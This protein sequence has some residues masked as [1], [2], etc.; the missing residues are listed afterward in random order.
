MRPESAP[1]LIGFLTY[2]S[3]IQIYD[4]INNGHSHIICDVSSTFP[5]LTTFLVDPLVHFEQ[6]ERYLTFD[7]KHLELIFNWI[8]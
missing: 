3:K 2:N 6:I 8:L 1:P 5:P 4:I 7:L